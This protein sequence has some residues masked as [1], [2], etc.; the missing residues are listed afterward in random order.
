MSNEPGQCRSCEYLNRTRK[1]GGDCAL[2]SMVVNEGDSCGYWTR[3]KGLV[4]GLY[5][6]DM[7]RKDVYANS[8]RLKEI[9]KK[10]M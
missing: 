9:D 7:E 1:D 6:N 5:L 8:R 2:D 3:F 10:E 4:R